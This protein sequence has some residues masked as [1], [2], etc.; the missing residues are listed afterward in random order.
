MTAELVGGI[1]Q[2][3]TGSLFRLI[4]KNECTVDHLSNTDLCDL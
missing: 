3:N 2:L 1:C 4:V